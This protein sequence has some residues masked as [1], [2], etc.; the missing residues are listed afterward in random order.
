VL[1]EAVVDDRKVDLLREGFD[2]AVRVNPAPDS[3][4]TGR[5]LGRNRVFFVA[6]PGVA[7]RVG[8]AGEAP[9]RFAWPAVIRRGWGD[10]GGWTLIG[11][12]G[13]VRVRA[14]PR[15]DLSSPLAIRDAVLAGA[16]AAFLPETL[17]AAELAAGRLLRLGVRHGEPEEVWIVHASGRLPSGRLR[18]LID[19]MVSVFA[20]TPLSV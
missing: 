19:T 5:L 16:G 20:E 11:P 10:D 3:L 8:Y 12:K 6:T 13:P 18:A 4:L 9:E 1:L 7:Q 15:L 14:L 17:V 2:A